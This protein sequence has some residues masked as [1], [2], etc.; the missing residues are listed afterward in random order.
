MSKITVG[1]SLYE[2]VSNNHRQYIYSCMTHVIYEYV[3]CHYLVKLQ[4]YDLFSVSLNTF[5]FYILSFNTGD[6]CN[7]CV[8]EL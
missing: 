3:I 4:C 8:S 6:I 1:T 7:K 2:C 5:N